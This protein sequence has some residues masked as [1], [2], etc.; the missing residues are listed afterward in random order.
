[1]ETIQITL[2]AKLLK[3]TNIAA[4]RQEVNRLALIRHALEEHLKRLRQFEL[5]VRDR[6]GYM[7]HRQRTDEYRGWRI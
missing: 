7:A 4:K 2:D 1:M 3:A 5:E 6:R